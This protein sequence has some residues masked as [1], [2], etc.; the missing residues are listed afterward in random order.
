MKLL[1]KSLLVSALLATPFAAAN[2]H[3]SQAAHDAWVKAQKID[4]QPTLSIK[5]TTIP[6]SEAHTSDS[7]SGSSGSGGSTTT[8]TTN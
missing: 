5:T 3:E 6:A 7:S 4:V 8:S 2:A 1:Y